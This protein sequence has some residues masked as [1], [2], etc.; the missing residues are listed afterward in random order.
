MPSVQVEGHGIP[1]FYDTAFNLY[2]RCVKTVFVFVIIQQMPEPTDS[3][4]A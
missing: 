1:S 2:I 4:I 3:K